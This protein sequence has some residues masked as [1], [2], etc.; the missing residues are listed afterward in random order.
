MRIW[1][2]SDSHFGHDKI[3]EL[4][5]RP[6][7][8][9]DR[10]LRG[11]DLIPHNDILLHLGDVS[12]GRDSH[13]QHKLMT[14]RSSCRKWLVLG[15]HDNHS[16]QWYMNMQWDWIGKSMTLKAFG[17][18]ILFSHEPKASLYGTDDEN[19]VNVHGHTHSPKRVAEY[20]DMYTDRHILYSVE[21]H[22]YKPVLLE[23]LLKGVK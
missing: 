8:Y 2:T 3:I 16:L 6:S 1:I 10:I 14:T 20:A 11:I 7:D 12:L 17:K 13:W 22:N 23:T 21:E 9:A 19:W 4:A 15:N 5:H 18:D